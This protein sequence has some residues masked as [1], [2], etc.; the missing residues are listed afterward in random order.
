MTIALGRATGFVYVRT[1]IRRGFVLMLWG[2]TISYVHFLEDRIGIVW[3]RTFE[4]GK[5]RYWF[6]EE[7]KLWAK[8]NKN[9]MKFLVRN[10]RSD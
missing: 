5:R 9:G 8:K 3:S 10:A 6:T 4:I 1:E 2:W 7:W